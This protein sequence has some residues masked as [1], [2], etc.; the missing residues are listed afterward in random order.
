M[1]H[2]CE[3][4]S[5]TLQKPL[6]SGLLFIDMQKILIISRRACKK[7]DVVKGNDSQL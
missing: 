2:T 4:A 1:K 7:G 6:L 5:Y 3:L